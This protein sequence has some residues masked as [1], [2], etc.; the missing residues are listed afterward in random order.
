MDT[1]RNVI[2][3]LERVN[4][5]YDLLRFTL[6]LASQLAPGLTYDTIPLSKSNMA[7]ENYSRY[8]ISPTR[9][10][11][12][13]LFDILFDPLPSP[14][15]SEFSLEHVAFLLSFSRGGSGLK[16]SLYPF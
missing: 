1:Q 15:L 16:K 11:L 5:I 13:P 10:T 7:I 6:T 8:L 14:Y 12:E 9:P 4:Y 2:I 3:D